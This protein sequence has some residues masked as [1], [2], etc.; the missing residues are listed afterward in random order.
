VPGGAR[1]VQVS[2]RSRE[3]SLGPDAPASP[4]WLQRAYRGAELL[5]T[6][7]QGARV[8]ALYGRDG[9][10]A[11]YL[12]GA[13]ARTRRMRYAF[14]F[15]A[16]MRPPRAAPGEAGLVV[17]EVEWA[18]EDAGVLYVETT[19]LT[20]AAS[21][22]GRNAYVSAIDLARRRT[23][24]RSP[25]LVANARTFVLA[26]DALVTGYGFTREADFLYLL[27]RRT[28]RV[29]DRL[30]LPSAPERIVRHGNRLLVRTYDHD[31]VVEL[32]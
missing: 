20:Y 3:P 13:D 17:A 1:L 31:V 29:R 19:H 27:D 12:L 23:L 16:F 2:S 14:D 15:A 11:R 4:A 9:S 26:G 5:R 22:F 32:R 30:P 6:I 21:S 18:R 7:R 24:W 25:A 8:F 10:S 28:G